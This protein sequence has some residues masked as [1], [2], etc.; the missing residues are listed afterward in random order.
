MTP[1][2]DQTL[3]I[4]TATEDEIPA[5]L[6][7]MN[8]AF[9]EENED[10]FGAK[11]EWLLCAYDGKK[12]AAS[13]GY[14]PFEVAF[15]GQRVRNAAVTA[16]TTDPQYRRRGLV[17]KLM[18]GL[19]EKAKEEGFPIASLWA[20]M[21][22]LYQRY[23]YG[24]A[25]HM[26]IYTVDPRFSAFRVP[27][28]TGGVTR[29]L[30]QSE[31]KPLIMDIFERSRE[32]K[33]LDNYRPDF[34]WNALFRESGIK[35]RNFA[36]HF[37]D[38]GVAQGYAFY[39]QKAKEFD[40]AGPNLELRILDFHWVTIDAYHALWDW[41]RKHDLARELKFYFMPDDDP[42][43]HLLLEPRMLN[44]NQFDGLW[45]RVVDVPSALEARGYT[46]SGEVTLTVRDDDLCSWN[47]GSWTLTASGGGNPGE[48]RKAT[49]GEGLVM[50]PNTLASLISGFAS[51]SA[52]HMMGHIE[53]DTP[54]AL[55]DAD[56]I[57]STTRKPH[58]SFEF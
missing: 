49:T 9:A 16:V 44:K 8:Y 13:S 54:Q 28:Q 10:V 20:S 48:V 57:F 50:T 36:I 55:L 38:H 53:C 29:R 26:N 33:T 27:F 34:Y 7:T 17:R 58:C 6:D 41:F 39:R 5:I 24:L 4:R 11:P 40:D 19:L 46:Q 52:L 22:A 14:F 43:P 47:N 15:N 3:Q 42:A 32:G 56:R 1:D 23:G 31:A 45:L 12:V 51:A 2:N 30:D 21:G 37:D 25:A 35:G 18:T